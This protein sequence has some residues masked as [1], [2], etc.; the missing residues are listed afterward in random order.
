M[1]GN[2]NAHFPCGTW[3][4]HR[5]AAGRVKVSSPVV[6]KDQLR[7]FQARHHAALL[8]LSGAWRVLP[9]TNVGFLEILKGTMQSHLC[10]AKAKFKY[11]CQ[12]LDGEAGH[13]FE[14]SLLGGDI[15]MQG[16]HYRKETNECIGAAKLS[17]LFL[18]I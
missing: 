17:P 12:F 4:D 5:C 3:E 10:G 16:A 11:A 2:N 6:L 15:F 18:F 7:S 14:S 9:Q 13:E 8:T 1:G